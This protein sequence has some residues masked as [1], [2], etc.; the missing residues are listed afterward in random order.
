VA[1]QATEGARTG[2][3]AELYKVSTLPTGIIN[4]QTTNVA[5]AMCL[6]L[7]GRLACAFCALQ[8]TGVTLPFC[9]LAC[10]RLKNGTYVTPVTAT[11]AAVSAAIALHAATKQAPKLAAPAEA[12]PPHTAPSSAAEAAA[13]A[14]ALPGGIAG[15]SVT[16]A[17]HALEAVLA[18]ADVA[19][20]DYE[21][22]A[23]WRAQMPNELHDADGS[24]NDMFVDQVCDCPAQ[25]G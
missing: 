17:A 24:D 21:L 8:I 23:R 1:A 6:M 16:Q 9:L 12:Q 18:A 13:A 20:T 10:R 22:R 25:R 19:M 2:Q 7:K 14:A 11:H 3:A 4:L 15:V 5:P